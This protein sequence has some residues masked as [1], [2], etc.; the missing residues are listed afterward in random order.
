M[1]LIPA[2]EI[3]NETRV[4]NSRFVTTLAPAFSIEEAKSFISRIKTEFIDASHNVPVFIIGHGSTMISHT[5]DDGE[6][7]GTAGRP[8]L[9]VLQGSGLGDVVAVITRYFGGTKLGKGGLVRAYGDAIRSILE[10][11]PLAQKAVTHKVLF[12]IPYSLFERAKLLVNNHHGVILDELF[13]ADVTITCRLLTEQ[14][15]AF[16]RNL[17]ELTQGNIFAEIIESDED[18]ILPITK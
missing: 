11:T 8:A 6:P 9:A 7:S 17:K 3:R 1:K 10:I 4:E 2:S 13:L 5:S 15:D 12:T 16:N 14:Y 18:T